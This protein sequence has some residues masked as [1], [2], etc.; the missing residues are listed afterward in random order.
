[1]ATVADFSK[2]INEGYTSKGESIT[3]GG[4]I[5]NGE[6]VADTFEVYPSFIY[7]LK[8]ATVAIEYFLI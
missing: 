7:L 6:A 8:S 1:M 5:L 3:L 4:A 2:Y